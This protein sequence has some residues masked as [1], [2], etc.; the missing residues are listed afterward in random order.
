M[1]T[2]PID[3][4]LRAQAALRNA[5]GLGPEMFPVQAFVGMISD[6]V[7][8]LRSQGMSD[9]DIAELIASNSDIEISATD[10]SEN[11]APPELRHS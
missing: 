5:A 1:K 10:I 7:E 6:E 2:F 9:A 11:Y 3:Q 4:A 8:H